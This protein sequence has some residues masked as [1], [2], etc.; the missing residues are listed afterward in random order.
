MKREAKEK[1]RL[2]LL[3]QW[4]QCIAETIRQFGSSE[5]LKA[6]HAAKR[7]QAE[8]PLH[9]C[10]M[11]K[12]S[13]EKQLTCGQFMQDQLTEIFDE[14]CRYIIR[15]YQLLY[16]KN[17]MDEKKRE[18]LPEECQFAFLAIEAF[19]DIKNME[20]PS[21]VRLFRLA[22]RQYP[23]STNSSVRWASIWIIQLKMREKN[24]RR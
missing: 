1:K 5:L 3:K 19:E 8:Y 4:K 14:Y 16:Q 12:A 20:Y 18:Q 22:L 10:W 2:D 6:E 13:L 11:K 17:M 7:I 23:A 21:A 9:Y 24:I 15:F